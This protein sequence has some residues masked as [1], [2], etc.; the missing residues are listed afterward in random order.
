MSAL[1]PSHR[2]SL[3]WQGLGTARWSLLVGALLHAVLLAWAANSSFLPRLLNS[4]YVQV[5]PYH[6]LPQSFR[7]FENTSSLTGQHCESN[8]N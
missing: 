8:H 5:H 7:P 6:L 2:H 4:S 3:P 1:L